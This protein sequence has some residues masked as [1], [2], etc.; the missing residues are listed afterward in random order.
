[1]MFIRMLSRGHHLV[2]CFVFVVD[3]SSQ[4]CNFACLMM[5][6]HQLFNSKL[7]VM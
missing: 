5:F 2:F 7:L 4:M 3:P 6:A 1:M